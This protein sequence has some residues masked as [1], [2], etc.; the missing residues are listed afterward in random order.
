[1][2]ASV[3]RKFYAVQILISDGITM[4]KKLILTALASSLILAGCGQDAQNAKQAPLP[5]VAVQDVSV[6]SHQQSK[7]YIGRIEAVEDTAITAQVSGYLQS[8]HFNEGQMVE[9]GQLLYSIEPSSFEAEVASAKASVAQANA[10]LKK[11][12]LDFN[13]GK[14]LLPKGSISQSEFDALTANLLGSQAQLEASQ[15]QLNAA[16]VQLSHTKIIAPFSGRISDTKVSKGDLVSPSSGVLTTL[17][18]LDPIHASF[19][20]SERER[21]ELGMDRIEGD[22]AGVEVQIMLEN[23]EVFEHLGQLD[24]LGNRINLNTGTIAMRAIA[25]N[26]NQRLLP[27]QHV[28]VDLREKQSIDVVT[29]PRRAVQTDLE[30][31]FVMVLVE[32]EAAPVAERRNIEMGRQV[33]GGVIVHSGLEKNDAVITQG[34][35][36]VR[37]GMSVRIQPSAEQAE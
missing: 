22:G 26:P 9:K 21:I 7:S 3:L 25:D 14:N 37:N 12:E 8:R 1:M 5:L 16:N 11:A 15:A 36:R 31:D 27:G 4:R 20:I 23:G 34:L 33:E 17:V 2:V 30:G 35:Q 29:I 18:S 6:V 28:R 19:S 10:N 13:R 24:F 32:G